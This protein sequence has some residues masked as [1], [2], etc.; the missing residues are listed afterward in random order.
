[1][2]SVGSLFSGIGGIEIGLE[3][4]K[5]FE[6]KWFVERDEYAKAVLRK[7]W[8]R[9]PI[10]SDVTAINWSEIERVDV[11]TG[12]FPCQDISNAGQRKGI[13][14]ERSGLWNYYL[15]AIRQ[16][17]PK[18]A[19]IENVAALL[20]RGLST[21]L[22]DLASVGY[23]AE[24]HCLPASSLGALH[25]RDRIF[26]IAYANT[27]RQLQSEG[28][29]KDIGQ[30]TGDICEDVSDTNNEGQP[31][32]RQ[33]KVRHSELPNADYY[34]YWKQRKESLREKNRRET[35]GSESGICRVANGVPNRVDRIR[36][37]GNAVVPQVAQF[38]GE[39]IL[40][41]END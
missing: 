26:I 24:W 3:L 39:M 19:L 37:L 40:K 17:R 33:V 10:Y 22:A 1:M 29:I 15:E 25:R 8:P 36:C 12:G 30:R 23:D 28:S 16:I 38:L 20:S 32:E 31:R 41:K 11:L 34:Y 4:T 7:K 13:K 14:G 35:W 6:T 5:K 18:Y 21:V 27:Q 2:L 9:V